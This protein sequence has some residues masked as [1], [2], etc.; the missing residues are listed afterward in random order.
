MIRR[1]VYINNFANGVGKFHLLAWQS[2][3]KMQVL[4][5]LFVASRDPTELIN[6]KQAGP[7]ALGAMP[8]CDVAWPQVS[9]APLKKRATSGAANFI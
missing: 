6:T 7:Q 2:L 4:V 1:S 8:P 3:L 5:P 9:S